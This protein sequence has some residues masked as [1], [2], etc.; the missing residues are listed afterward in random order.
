M[1]TE[2]IYEIHAGVTREQYEY[3]KAN[4]G[5]C[6]LLMP[7]DQATSEL[8]D[9]SYIPGLIQSA[10]MAAVDEAE[11]DWPLIDTA[12]IDSYWPAMAGWPM[13]V[14]AEILRLTQDFVDRVYDESVDGPVHF[15]NPTPDE[16]QRLLN[17]Y[18][19]LRETFRTSP[20]MVATWF[21]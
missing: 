4:A 6:W 3:L 21:K 15:F 1:A 13:E 11:D 10:L 17:A 18:P 2:P 8:Y 19:I 14:R 20:A 9:E 12:D 16:G 5:Y 7:G